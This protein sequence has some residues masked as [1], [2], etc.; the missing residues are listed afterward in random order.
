[1]KCIFTTTMRFKLYTAYIP[2]C[3]YFNEPHGV[4][5]YSRNISLHTHLNY[6]EA[7]DL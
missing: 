2:M 3:G 7:N 5:E 4:Q 1:M 6:N